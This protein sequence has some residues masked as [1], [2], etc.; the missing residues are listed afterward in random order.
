V[1]STGTSQGGQVVMVSLAAAN[2]G[3]PELTTDKL[4]YAPGDTVTF[5]GMGWGAN[6]VVTISIHEDPQQH[7]DRTI[8]VTADA[9]GSFTNKSFAIEEQHLLVRFVATATGGTS[10]S[11]AQTTFT[12]GR[13][14][15][16]SVTPASINVTAGSVTGNYTVDVSMTGGPGLCSMTWALTGLHA[17]ITPLNFPTA[18]GFN[19]NGTHT[20]T[21]QL[22]TD[23]ATPLGPDTFTVTVTKGAGC[24]SGGSTSVSGSSAVNVTAAKVWAGTI[25]TA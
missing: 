2:S 10:G 21:F 1:G 23:V 18:T 4:D 20:I 17:S 3:G 14:N 8:V 16:L 11:R 13:P 5:S 6:E 7:T 24:A 9:L 12:D 19:G 22:A 15:S 25:S